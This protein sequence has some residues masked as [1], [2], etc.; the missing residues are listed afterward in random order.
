MNVLLMPM[1]SYVDCVFSLMTQGQ[2][3]AHPLPFCAIVVMSGTSVLNALDKH[4][5]QL[6][7]FPFAVSWPAVHLVVARTLSLP[8][9][10][11]SLMCCF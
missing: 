1:D 6:L 3:Q 11:L 2:D 8:E 4:I 7:L 9:S 10:C 5:A